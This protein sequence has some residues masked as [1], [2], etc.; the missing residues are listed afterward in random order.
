MHYLLY[1]MMMGAT[2]G[3]MTIIDTYPSYQECTAHTLD[4]QLYVPPYIDKEQIEVFWI[5]TDKKPHEIIDAETGEL[6]LETVTQ[7]NK[8]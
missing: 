2:T 5:C 7:Q 1:I 4:L 8:I 6:L 3:P